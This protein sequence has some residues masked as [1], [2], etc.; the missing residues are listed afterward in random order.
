[1]QVRIEQASA[2]DIAEIAL[3]LGEVEQYYGGDNTPGD[4][5][6]IGDA[7]FGPVP[8]ATCLVARDGDDKVVAMASYSFL[9]PAA[10]S[11]RSLYLKELYVR[12][13][14]R[15]QGVGQQMM[16]ELA[17]IAQSAGCSRM[18]WT[19]DIDNPTAL[20]F[21]EKMG[22]PQNGGKVFFRLPL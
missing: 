6:E 10:G 11:T 18:E 15:L 21:Y 13:H 17:R 16:Q 3:L 7:L 14:A 19:G 4:P 1:M 5:E 12:E 8:V 20:A 9:W 22:V 2:G